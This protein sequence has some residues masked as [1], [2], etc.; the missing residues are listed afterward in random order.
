M[1][2][3]YSSEPTRIRSALRTRF[4]GTRRGARPCPDTLS[5]ASVPLKRGPA[6]SETLEESPS[7]GRRLIA[8]RSRTGAYRSSGHSIH[9]PLRS[10][11]PCL[12]DSGRWPIRGGLPG[13]RPCNPIDYGRPAPYRT[14]AQARRP[15]TQ[16]R[17][18]RHISHP[19]VKRRTQ[20]NHTLGCNRLTARRSGENT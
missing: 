8:P 5:V 15:R 16:L 13:V 6:E 10:R 1:P 4:S 18:S 20:S 19:E 11:A 7:G 2:R 17:S 3:R 12:N 14:S 9:R